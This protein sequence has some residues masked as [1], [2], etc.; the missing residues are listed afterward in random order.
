MS[1]DT[2]SASKKTK[3]NNPIL[4]GIIAIAPLLGTFLLLRWI[5]KPLRQIGEKMVTY[6]MQAWN[7]FCTPQLTLQY[8][9]D[10]ALN[11][12]YLFLPVLMLC[13]LG[14]F[15]QTGIGKKSF[16]TLSRIL[17]SIPFLGFIYN[18][19]KQI[20]D[21]LNNLCSTEKFQ[22]VA[23]LKFADHDHK[24][25]GFIT[26]HYTE[27]DGTEVTSLFLPTSPN[28]ASGHTVI[29]NRDQVQPSSLSLEE[30]GKM[31]VSAGIITPEIAPPEKS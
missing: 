18:I 7:Q 24:L 11:I 2:H 13:I 17:K 30:A 28:L 26:G 1:S 8:V 22:G 10:T 19:F 3:K 31:I 29:V 14:A 4:T 25:V 6:L 12:L 23:Y 20:A 5:Y 21:S 16:N 15:Y 9:P 27:K